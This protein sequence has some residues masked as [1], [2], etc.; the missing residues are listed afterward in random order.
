MKYK[1][2]KTLIIENAFTDTIKNRN[3]S[4]LMGNEQD[5]DSVQK[6]LTG[7]H[8]AMGAAKLNASKNSAMSSATGGEVVDAGEEAKRAMQAHI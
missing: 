4:F 7:N 5:P 1:L 2:N 3:T 8:E 6:S